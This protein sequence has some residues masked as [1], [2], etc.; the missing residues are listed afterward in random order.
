MDLC[1]LCD[2]HDPTGGQLCPACTRAT[3]VRLECLP[4]LYDGLLPFLAP[5]SAIGQGRS[6]KGGH[7]PLP[8]REDILDLRGVMVGTLEDWLS[9]VREERCM[10]Q[11]ASRPG[12]HGRLTAAVSGLLA[13]LSWIAVSWPEAG[14]FAGEIRNLTRDVQSIVA[15]AVD[16]VRG[17]RI[18]T[19][20][21]VHDDGGVC[22][23][24][25]R[26]GHGERVVTCS[27]CGITYP[28][29]M[30]AGL[31]TLIDADADAAA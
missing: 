21:A 12:V 2:Q 27:W 1:Q 5:S 31:K 14:L 30:W 20:P 7:A 19:C 3:R 8:V 22:G 24:V 9:A 13:N 11:L 18:G 17:T 4:A 23:A 16:Q 26:L 29:A 6:G 15:P 25:L 28:P 10:Q